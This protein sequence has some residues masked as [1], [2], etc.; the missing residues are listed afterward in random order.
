MTFAEAFY[1]KNV[2][3]NE[4]R[5]QEPEDVRDVDKANDLKKT[6][7]TDVRRIYKLRKGSLFCLFSSASFASS[8]RLFSIVSSSID[9]TSSFPALTLFATASSLDQLKVLGSVVVNGID[10]YKLSSKYFPGNFWRKSTFH[11][12][13]PF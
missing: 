6:H 5:S 11:I 9:S 3:V 12:C 13:T 7:E 10:F 2:I 4:D 1:V 8:S